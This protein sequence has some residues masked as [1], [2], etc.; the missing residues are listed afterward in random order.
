MRLFYADYR[1]V[2]VRGSEIYDCGSMWLWSMVELA[3]IRP[4]IISLAAM[5]ISRQIESYSLLSCIDKQCSEL[6]D[7]PKKNSQLVLNM[8]QDRGTS[9]FAS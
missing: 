3:W 9:G 7:E 2:E 4:A 8:L 5:Y 1:L 6:E